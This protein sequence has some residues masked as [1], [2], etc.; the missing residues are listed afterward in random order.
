MGVFINLTLFDQTLN[1]PAS[2]DRPRTRDRVAWS[3]DGMRLTSSC[4]TAS[5]GMTASRSPARTSY[6]TYDLG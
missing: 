5:S 1:T 6:A 3:E 4:A 2:I